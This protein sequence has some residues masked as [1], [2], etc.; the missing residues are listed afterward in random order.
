M[1]TVYN[2]RL[3]CN[4]ENSYVFSWGLEPP[5]ACLHNT[6]HTIDTSSIT[7]INTVSE[8]TVTAVDGTPNDAIF[9]LS[10]ITVDVPANPT[11]TQVVTSTVS[12]PFDMYIWQMSI[13]QIPANIGDQLTVAVAPDTVIGY[14]TAECMSGT[15]LLYVSNT[16]IENITRGSEIGLTNGVNTEYPG[17]V[18]TIDKVNGIVHMENDLTHTYAG[19][20]GYIPQTYVLV[21]IYPIRNI[22]FDTAERLIIGN[23]GL[24]TRMIPANTPIRVIYYDNTISTV[25]VKLYVLI[26]YYYK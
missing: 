3:F 12:Y 21:T 18:I 13:A 24:K 4:T 23:K 14:V 15:K 1:T 5:V 16:V 26:E 22:T 2:Y 7:I 9:Q 17:R 6:S 11:S 10:A 8:S 19:P 20:S 25:A